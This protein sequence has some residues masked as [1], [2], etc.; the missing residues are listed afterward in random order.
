MHL[1]KFKPWHLSICRDLRGYIYRICAILGSFL[2]ISLDSCWLFTSQNLFLSLQTSFA[3]VVRPKN[4]L[5]SFG[6]I[7]FTHSSCIS[8]IWPNFLGFLKNIGFFSKL[9][10]FLWNFCDGLCENGSK[11]SCIASHL[12]YNNVSCILDVCLLCWNDC[13]L[14]RLDWAEP[15]MFL[16]LHITCSCIFTHTYLRFSI[17]LYIDCDWCFSVCVFLSLFP[18]LSVSCFMA[19]KRKST[20]SRNPLCSGASSSSDPTPFHIWFHDD[21][22]WQDFSENFSRQGIHSERQVILLD[23]S[24]I[25]LPTVIH[26]RG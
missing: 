14:V 10:E 15:M 17:F 25:D 4:H 20:L 1:S 18:F 2:S 23:F 12:H 26:S 16:L 21:K 13:V 8:C 11:S 9:M 6:M 7:L 3:R 24:N 19:P 22:A 5:L